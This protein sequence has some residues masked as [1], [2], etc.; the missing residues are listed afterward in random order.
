MRSSSRALSC[1]RDV[2]RW[3]KTTASAAATMLEMSAARKS[4]FAASSS[5]IVTAL[6]LVLVAIQ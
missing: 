1:S 3:T 2:A 5:S 4:A 6:Q